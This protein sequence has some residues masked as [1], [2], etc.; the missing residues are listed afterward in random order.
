M[1][2]LFAK[3]TDEIG[4]LTVLAVIVVEFRWTVTPRLNSATYHSIVMAGAPTDLDRWKRIVVASMIWPETWLKSGFASL[5]LALNV[6]NAFVITT[7]AI[8]T[9]RVDVPA[10][11]VDCPFWTFGDCGAYAGC[12]TAWSANV[13]YQHP[14]EFVGSHAD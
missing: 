4:T 1:G 9:F 14:S 3:A 10:A 11:S 5:K 2:K 8:V 6:T 7:D 12:S 13:A